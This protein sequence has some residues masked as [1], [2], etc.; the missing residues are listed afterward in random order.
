MVVARPQN[1]QLYPFIELAKYHERITRDFARATQLS[2]EAKALLER[3]HLR[4]GAARASDHAGL[5]RRIER[6]ERR[7][8]RVAA[9]R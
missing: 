7:A 5:L 1:R 8:S 6:L 9:V 2:H 3:H 4:Y